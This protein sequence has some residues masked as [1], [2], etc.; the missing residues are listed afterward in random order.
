MNTLEVNKLK[1]S[2]KQSIINAFA[3]F[4]V[5]WVSEINFR[6]HII[7]SLLVL[8]AGFIYKLNTI[9][10]VGILLCIGL[11]LGAEI[12]NTAIEH[13]CDLTS[14]EI[15]PEIKAIKD[16]S[17]FGVLFL[18]MISSIVGIIIFLPKIIYIFKSI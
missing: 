14:K 16:I 1:Y 18:A 8:C 9:E 3:G 11:V 2:R 10:W 4:K 13:L 6:I 15:K 17:A 12:F 7:I 5:I